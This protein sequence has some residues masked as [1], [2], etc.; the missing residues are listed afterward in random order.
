MDGTQGTKNALT[1]K[2]V[3]KIDLTDAMGNINFGGNSGATQSKTGDNQVEITG[4]TKTNSTITLSTKAK[5][6]VKLEQDAKGITILSVT[7][8]DKIDFSN[9]AN[10]L[11]T[12]ISATNFSTASTGSS[13][14]ASGAY[15][16]NDKMSDS[17]F[18]NTE[19]VKAK[20]KQAANNLNDNQKALVAVK[21]NDE[22]KSAIYLVSGSGTN[23]NGENITLDLLGI[24]GHKIDNGDKLAANGV[25]E[26]A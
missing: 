26:F 13:I 17:E 23:G 24:V 9:V 4:V 21:N 7:S 6:T 16:W 22:S 10:D 12:A 19:Q 5:E 15:V 8:G 11:S 3:T 2:N 14:S 25:I 18:S 20:I 1:V